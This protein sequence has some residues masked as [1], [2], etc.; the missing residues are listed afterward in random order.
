M[1]NSTASMNRVSQRS[2]DSTTHIL[3]TSI[4]YDQLVEHQRTMFLIDKMGQPPDII[5]PVS[6]NRRLNY[7]SANLHSGGTHM[8]NVQVTNEDEEIVY[9]SLTC[10]QNF[11]Y[12]SRQD[13]P[14]VGHS[15]SKNQQRESTK[16]NDR[17]FFN[18]RQR[19]VH[20]YDYPKMQDGLHAGDT[21]SLGYQSITNTMIE[22]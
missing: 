5:L 3:P 2:V 16:D 20:H 19:S 1:N 17:T 18:Q 14:D 7:G 13:L 11:A 8:P 12:N 21:D 10:T 22:N 15:G 9:S 4:S 6:K